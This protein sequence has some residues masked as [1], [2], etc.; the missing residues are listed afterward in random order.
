MPE[1]YLAL[2]ISAVYS[3]EEITGVTYIT[4]LGDGYYTDSKFFNFLQ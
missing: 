4:S 2:P 1:L 3:I